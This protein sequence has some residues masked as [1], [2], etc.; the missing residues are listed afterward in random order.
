M[1]ERKRD[2]QFG[3]PTPTICRDG[4]GPTT[5]EAGRCARCGSPRLLIHPDLW[6]LDLAHIDCDAFYASVEKRDDPTLRDKP[7]IVGGG[8]RGVVAACCYLARTK[9]VRSA[10]PMFKARRLCPDAVVRPPDIPRYRVESRRIRAMMEQLTPVIEPLALDE[11]YLDLSEAEATF[12]APPAVLLAD[13]ASR[14]EAEVGVTVSIG[15]SF[16]K[17]LAKFASDQ[18]KPRG[19]HVIG[20]GEAAAALAPLPVR[21]LWGVGPRMAEKLQRDGYRK[22]ADIAAA[23]PEILT[24]RYG[25]QGGRLALYAN[26]RD[27]RRVEP[28]RPMKSVSVE[29]T[30]REDLSN[31]DDLDDAL[32]ALCDRLGRRLADKGAAIDGVVLKLKEAD[33]TQR[34][35]QRPLPAPTNAAAMI[36]D[37]A[38]ELLKAALAETP[39]RRYRLIGVVGRASADARSSGG[40]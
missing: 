17:L 15:L 38:A 11:A 34:T 18:D 28:D 13:L 40:A 3:D 33:F 16:N 10:M 12:G 5:A 30:F 23:D 24:R 8:A 19:F 36:A 39:G 4:C 2:G 25:G 27:D 26:G 31:P 35:R 32:R 22:V 37:A 9:G 29:T 20:P 14:I 21:A 1:A 7:V 6:R